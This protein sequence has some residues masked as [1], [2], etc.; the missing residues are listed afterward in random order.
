M[1]QKTRKPPRAK[2]E[3]GQYFTPTNVADLMVSMLRTPKSGHL[4][5]P[6]AGE[7]VFVDTLLKAG[8]L[9]ITPIEIDSRLMRASAVP[10]IYE[11]FV[12]WK[13]DRQYHAVVGNPPYI[14][15]KHLGAEQKTEIQDSPY[16]GTVLNSLSDYLTV[17][18][19]KSIECLKDGGELIFVTPDFWMFTQHSLLLREFM[20]KHGALTDVVTFGESSVFRGVSSSIIIF[21]FVKG[22]KSRPVKVHTYCGPRTVG[23]A[24]LRLSDKKL[25]TKTTVPAF[26]TSETWSLAP[27]SVTLKLDEL[28][29]WATSSGR[30]RYDT[31]GD[32][33]DIANG[34]VSGLDSAFKLSDSQYA[35]LPDNEKVATIPVV[36]AA[37]IEELVTSTVT[38]YCF[39]PLSTPREDVATT[40][41]TVL[42]HLEGYRPE[43][44]R[45]YALKKDLAFWEWSF[46]RS[47]KAHFDDRQKIFV[48]CKERLSCRPRARFALVPPGSIATQDITAISM[49]T[50]T[51]EA[52]EYLAGYL[53]LD[54]VTR[55]VRVRGLMKGGVAEFSERPLASIPVRRIDWRS[56]E[57]RRIHDRVVRVVRAA[58]AGSISREVA[59]KRIRECFSR[60]GLPAGTDA[61]Q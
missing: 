8:Y 14:R 6:S 48:P 51:A 52:V 45:R 16:W 54:E 38:R 61:T 11:S 57:E 4:L 18:I 41:P 5:E 23:T 43:L 25:F 35:A 56:S 10:A 26:S 22:G 55:W 9:H 34:L 27:T 36:K 31:L 49:K 19:V 2:N 59:R 40:F 30:E 39:I 29:A 1:T 42:S 37:T 7:G 58:Q 20:L 28:Q 53:S 24:R 21:R 15:W 13:P 12:S 32:L 33:C 3:H 47:S 60:L 17:F 50:G 46:L 44:E